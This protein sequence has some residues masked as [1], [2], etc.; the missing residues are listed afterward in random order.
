[1][2]VACVGM[3]CMLYVSCVLCLWRIYCLCHVLE[4]VVCYF[5]FVHHV[6]CVGMSGRWV[7]VG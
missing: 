4:S 1:M 7:S 2:D 5:V 3:V 6:Y